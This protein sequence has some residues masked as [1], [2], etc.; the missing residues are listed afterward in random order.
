M[1]CQLKREGV[2]ERF[3]EIDKIFK[4]RESN[5]RFFFVV[6]CDLTHMNYV[7]SV[8]VDTVDLRLMV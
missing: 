4:L 7:R 6:V 3:D 1:V 2:I 5:L 8:P